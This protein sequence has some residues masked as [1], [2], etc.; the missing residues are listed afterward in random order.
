MRK[1]LTLWGSKTSF[2]LPWPIIFL[3]K[4]S[5][6]LRFMRPPLD[7]ATSCAP[8]DV[9]LQTDPGIPGS[10]PTAG[11]AV[12]NISHWILIPPFRPIVVMNGANTMTITCIQATKPETQMSF[13]N[14]DITL[15]PATVTSIF[16][17]KDICVFRW[18]LKH[19]Y[20][21]VWDSG[22]LVKCRLKL[23]LQRPLV[24]I[25]RHKIPNYALN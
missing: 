8:G 11:W 24:K 25:S 3:L 15:A 7:L 4:T 14:G 23:W 5:Q 6:D 17:D 21:V 20:A 2:T 16:W 18:I 10:I 19:W 13:N 1:Q 22:P 9:T 12:S